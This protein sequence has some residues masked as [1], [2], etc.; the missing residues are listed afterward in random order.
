MTQLEQNLCDRLVAM[1]YESVN[2]SQGY[3][4]LKMRAS[5]DKV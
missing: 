5:V 4:I 2:I 1:G 3:F